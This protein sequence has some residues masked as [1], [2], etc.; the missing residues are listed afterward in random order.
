[1]TQGTMSEARSTEPPEPAP[2]TAPA[3]EAAA[4]PD[5]GVPDAA[6]PGAAAVPTTPVEAFDALYAYAA[7]RLAEQAYVLSGRRRM[8]REAVE[9][10]F[11][12]AWDRWP[13]V[14]VDRDP[15]GWVRAETHQYALSPWHRF[16]LAHRHPDPPTGSGPVRELRAALLELPPSYRRTLLLFDGL[17]MGLPEV[18]AETEASTPAAGHRLLHARA[19]IAARIPQL[20]DAEALRARMAELLV[21]RTETALAAP[22]SVRAGGERRVRLW[23]RGTVAL[24]ALIAAATAFTL[25]TAPTRYEPPL[26]PGE[27]VGGVPV[28]SG[29]QQLTPEDELLRARLHAEPVTGP[30]R[31]VPAPY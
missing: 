10:A 9:F 6:A 19:G 25:A 4:D 11:H 2:E 17:G 27:A 23:T 21:G 22:R 24:T 3:P 20:A 31:L 7:P 12:R 18:A 8:A 13:E 16:R 26:A 14:A 29:P 28:L 30:A 5:A 1:M 15:V